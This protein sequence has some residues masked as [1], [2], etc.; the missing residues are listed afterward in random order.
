MSS[1]ATE[2]LLPIFLCHM[3]LQCF[4]LFHSVSEVK[5]ESRAIAAE[6]AR[7]R[8]KLLSIQ[9]FVSFDIRDVTY[10]FI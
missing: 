1:H 2:F 3:P 7:S 4:G 10:F 5:E 9:L 6:T 8:C